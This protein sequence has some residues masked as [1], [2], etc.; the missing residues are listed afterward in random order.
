M[1]RVLTEQPLKE[2]G[3]S[4]CLVSLTLSGYPHGF[5][6]F[7]LADEC[8]SKVSCKLILAQSRS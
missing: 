5:C 4:L 8:L 6:L 3:Q 7:T 2:C 1:A